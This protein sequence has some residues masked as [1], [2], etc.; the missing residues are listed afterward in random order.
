[1]T[2]GESPEEGVVLEPELWDY[3]AVEPGQDGPPTVVTLTAE[4]IAAYARLAQNPIRGSR[5]PG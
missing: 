5:D 1:M 3:D 2:G 4:H